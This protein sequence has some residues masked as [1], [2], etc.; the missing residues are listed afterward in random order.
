MNRV[1]TGQY[2]VW[3][4]REERGGCRSKHFCSCLFSI[5]FVSYSICRLLGEHFRFAGKRIILLYKGRPLYSLASPWKE[6]A[7][8]GGTLKFIQNMGLNRHNSL[9]LFL[10]GCL[11]GSWNCKTAV[12]PAVH[13]VQA[14]VHRWVLLIPGVGCCSAR[15]YWWEPQLGVAVQVHARGISQHFLDHFSPILSSASAAGPHRP[16]SVQHWNWAGWEH[17]F[18]YPTSRSSLPNGATWLLTSKIAATSLRNPV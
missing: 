3:E 11:D 2:C 16:C 15:I 8:S 5:I 10:D 13:S 7:I 6:I 14:L 9:F 17:L 4:G 12:L 1:W 18:P